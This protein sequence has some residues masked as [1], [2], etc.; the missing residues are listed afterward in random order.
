MDEPMFTQPLMYQKIRKHT[1]VYQ[2]YTDKLLKEGLVNQ[3]EIEV[4]I[5]KDHADDQVMMFRRVYMNTTTFVNEL[6]RHRLR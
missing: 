1:N 3:E 5:S 4:R 6:S 2:L